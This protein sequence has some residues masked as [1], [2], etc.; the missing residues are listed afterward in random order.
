MRQIIGF[1]LLVV[2]LATC[3]PVESAGKLLASNQL[4]EEVVEDANGASETHYSNFPL[5]KFQILRCNDPIV[6]AVFRKLPMITHPGE[7][8]PPNHAE[9]KLVPPPNFAVC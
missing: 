1:T 4:Q 3:L 9:E 6:A 2:L 5:V 7:R 8:I